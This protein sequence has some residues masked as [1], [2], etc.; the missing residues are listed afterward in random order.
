MGSRI[1]ILFISTMDSA[2]W[3][4]SEELWSQAALGLATGG[5]SVAASV[6]HWCPLDARIQMLRERGIT[7]STRRQHPSLWDRARGKVTGARK[8]AVAAAVEKLL[9]GDRPQLVVHSSG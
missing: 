7:I 6:I 5:F 8:G 3:G 1:R 9:N 2:P 4:G